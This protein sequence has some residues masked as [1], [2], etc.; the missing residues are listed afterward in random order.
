MFRRSSFLRVCL[1]FWLFCF[2][3]LL[4]L[5]LI[6]FL[7]LVNLTMSCGIKSK[8]KAKSIKNQSNQNRIHTLTILLLFLCFSSQACANT[9]CVQFVE[10][11]GVNLWTENFGRKEN[12]A[13]LLISGG[14]AGAIMWPD[15]FCRRLAK[16]GFFVL[17]YDPR[18]IG[19][20]SSVDTPYDLLDMAKEALSICDAYG[21][22]KVHILGASMGA[23]LAMLLARFFPE[24]ILTIS[25]M[26]A[27]SDLNAVLSPYN[28]E[29]R[30][31]FPQKEYL[32][33]LGQLKARKYSDEE[34]FDLYLKIWK[35]LNGKEAPFDEML[36]REIVAL[37]IK[38]GQNPSGIK[39]YMSAMK[40]SLQLLNDTYA[41]IKVPTL[42]IQ[43][44]ADPIFS[45]EHGQDLAN[46]I[47]GSKLVLMR[48]MGH[49]LNPFF[50]EDLLQ[51]IKKH[52]Q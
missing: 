24:R 17:R 40:T 8:P 43:G 33:L 16:E 7:G 46:K 6:R 2:S 12:P 13:L 45:I 28:P 26:M 9:H 44:T 48:G 32:E 29:T 23:S 25:L 5:A 31:P 35:V 15:L 14:G 51:V 37:F 50:Y 18:D 20:S 39:N 47:A 3:R 19:Y 1:R 30:L 36:Y 4:L 21:I 10:A 42:I 34:K 22:D 49:N 27:T 38:R 41:Q 11:N 52:T